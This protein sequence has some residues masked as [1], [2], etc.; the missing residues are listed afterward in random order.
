M[1]RRFFTLDVFT[2]TALA[3]NPLAVVLDGQGLGDAGMQA[4]A[5]EFN[6]SETVFVLPP[7]DPRHR[8]KIR[9]FTPGRELPFAGHPTV[10]TAVLLGLLDHGKS[11]A[12]LAFGLEENVGPVAC[13][14]EVVNS[15]HGKATFTLPR[16]PQ[17][18][19]EIGDRLEIAAALDLSPG[20]IGFDDH[21]PGR[22]SAG[23]PF[24]LVPVESREAVDSA[25][26]RMGH[27]QAAFGGV[28]H[29]S[30]FIYCRQ[31]V[32]PEDAF[33]ARMFAPDMGIAEDPATGGAVAAFAGAIMDYDQPIDGEHTL[34][35]E[36]GYAMGRPSR[37]K[38]RLK[39]E[40]G[41]LI[42]AAIGGD[43]VVVSEGTLHL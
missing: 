31:P 12:T 20:D 2:P 38:L 36:Q 40:G 19:G 42:E 10:G 34:M 39:V 22:Y 21:R 6:I 41:Q 37:M 18:V 23:V 13:A 17:R 35:I 1:S 4:I 9:I 33:Y 8:A 28:D 7:D 27:W 11:H 15:Q 25:R 14:V 16:L 26:P 29:A 24:A 5:R 30:A 3:G 43:A 32:D